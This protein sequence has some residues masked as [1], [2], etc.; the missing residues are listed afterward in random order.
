M[1]QEPRTGREE[2]NRGIHVA[3][4]FCP[5]C[6]NKNE[7][8]AANCAFC[9]APLG[10]ASARAPITTVPILYL[11]PELVLKRSERLQHL[12][13]YPPDVL[14]F[15][16]MDDDQPVIVPGLRPTLML[17]RSAANAPSEMVDLSG[18]SPDLG[19]SRQHAQINF[20]GAY[21]LVDLSSTNGTWLNQA[22]LVP[23]RPYPLN[24]GDEVRLGSLRL[25]VYYRQREGSQ[26]NAEDML[27]LT[28]MPSASAVRQ[29]IT[30]T[31]LA[32]VIL[33]YL[34][35]LGDLQKA[36]AEMQSRPPGE[37]V[38]NTLSA[39][40]PELPIGL[41]LT[42]ASQAISLMES[43]VTPW[44]NDHE[45]DLKLFLAGGPRPAPEAAGAEMDAR[46]AA[47]ENLHAA[48]PGLVQK[49]AEHLA[50][51]LP[52][53]DQPGLTQRLFRALSTLATSPLQLVITKLQG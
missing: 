44:R 27:L 23:H 14:V 17:G 21:T 35:A 41:S 8:E 49:V 45:A 16:I 26:D 15:Y 43:F 38:I 19:V 42:G 24:S 30:A 5:V 6:K 31:Y 22:R 37:L 32:K 7:G 39:M 53:A 1:L 28:E 9:G 12:A 13:E 10:A 46:R 50:T 25:N 52:G 20:S 33:P 3:A 4:K 34:T 29:N 11:Q 40:R 47:E 2:L 18:Y 51:R 36:A 48:L